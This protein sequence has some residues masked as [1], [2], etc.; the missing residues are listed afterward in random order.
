MI[1][2]IIKFFQTHVV[3]LSLTLGAILFTCG[4]HWTGVFDFLEL[5][6]YDYRFHTVRGPLT[7]WRASDSTIINMGTDVVL[8]EVDDEAW[9][10][11][12]DNKVPWPYPRGDIWARAVDNISKA[13][14]KVIAFDIQFDSPDA[15]SEYLRSVSGN[16]PSDFQQYLPGHG[17]ILLA[18]SIQNAQDNGTK[19]VMD[20]KM[21]REPTRIPPSY[22]AYPVPE[23]MDVNPETG[24]INDMLDTD[25]FSRQYSIAGYMEHEPDIAYLTLGVKCVKAFLDIPDD[26]VPTFNADNLSWNFGDLNITSYGR[27]N[28]FLVNY[29]GPPSGYK[30]P[31]HKN[32]KPWGTFPRYSLSQILDTQDYDLPEDLDWMSQFI[33]GE[34]PDWI[35]S[36]EDEAER[37]DMM[38]MMGL[39]ADFDITQ[40]PFY[41]KIVILGVA[42]E[43][44]HDV[45]STPFYN[46][47]DLSQLTPGMETHANAI[48]TILHEN[49]IKVFG[50]KTTRYM[51]EG[52]PYPM[53]NFLLIFCLC[54]LAYILL[55]KIELHPIVAGIIIFSE[56]LVYYAFAMG[57][58][59]NDNWWFWKSTVASLLPGGLHEKYYDQL[60]VVLPG[61][62][63]SYMMPIVAPL[64]GLV[65]TYASNIIFQFLHEQQDKKFL[66]ETFGT[67]IAPKVLDKMY[68]EKQAPKL[69]GVEGHHTAFFSDIQNFSTF[70][71]AL[72][73]TRMVALMNEYLTVMSQVILDNEGTLD[74]YIGDAIVAFYGA[75]A[76]VE[77]H[78][79][80]S[81]TT[82]LLM[83]DALEDLRQKWRQENDWPDI[84]YSMQHRIG[85]NC[86][87]MVTG[88]M[89]SEMRM[90]YTMMGDTV[91]L[92]AR[93]ESSA[94]QYGVYNFVGENI[95]E[96]TKDEF[97]FR[98]LDFVQVK[99]KNIP[100]KVYELVSAKDNADNHTVNLIKVFE[101][102][103]DHYYQQQWD[104]ALAHFKKAEGMEDHFTSRN[105][106]PSAVF[107]ERCT[108]FKD[109]PPGKDW[110]GVWTMTSK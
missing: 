29:Y 67:Y 65:L 56:G 50:G 37:N 13:G 27:T 42:I 12:K 14:A 20:V 33:P 54:T 26:A 25:G 85:L 41:N 1:K 86:G 7:G 69:G 109:N 53:V 43:V 3:D 76:P 92:A 15:R 101:E 100:V 98:F 17:D 22:I 78:E 6:T 70:S 21:V 103:L 49:Y 36:I 55:T 30:I 75:P 4:L 71:E 51:V 40:S 80:K 106:T 59:A 87:K 64:A 47:M 61:P 107:I 28:N 82:A 68:E 97:I 16:L 5:K 104:K 90:N 24:L 35:L 46:Y 10:I 96:E 34:I 32:L 44:L 94:K 45:K 63:E 18:E 19:V 93:L 11:L 81:C 62:G 9:R 8:V 58:F 66:R 57:M 89:G 91:N 79:K 99:G 105:T 108:M 23:I 74:K 31:G 84:V 102:G 38:A 77:N 48:Q 72:E 52:A 60:Q 88:N 110:D 39:G 95:Y 83:E 73:P 2:N